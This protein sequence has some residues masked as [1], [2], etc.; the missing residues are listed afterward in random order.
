MLTAKAVIRLGQRELDLVTDFTGHF[1]DPVLGIYYARARMYDA[2]NRRFMAIDPIK[3][4][5]NWFAYA[6]NNPI[7]YVDP[8]GLYIVI[9]GQTQ[10]ERTVI[11]ANLQKLTSDRL[12]V[13]DNW[14][15]RHMPAPTNPELSRILVWPRITD[16][17]QFDRNLIFGYFPQLICESTV[18][19]LE[20][21]IVIALPQTP[22]FAAGTSLIRQ[23]INS[24]RTV[25]IQYASNHSADPASTR[26]MRAGRPTDV[27]IYF[28]STFRPVVDTFNI[29]TGLILREPIPIHIALGHELIHALAIVTGTVFRGVTDSFLINP[30]GRDIRLER[31]VSREEIATIGVIPEVTR[32]RHDVSRDITENVLRMEQG[33]NLRFGWGDRLFR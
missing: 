8:T 2:A 32:T 15:V 25:I 27:T 30:Q 3:D 9:V 16:N 19:V 7:K 20:S 10:A 14:R 4:G 17:M 21:H 12:W 13:D 29:D 31:G 28:S 6:N 18:T 24:P 5:W 1:F 22:E 33:L 23:L 11:L 26:D